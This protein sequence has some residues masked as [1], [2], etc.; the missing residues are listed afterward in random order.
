MP[1][2]RPNACAAT[3]CTLHLLPTPGKPARRP[4]FTNPALVS[5]ANEAMACLATAVI[6]LADLFGLPDA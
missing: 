5:K 6:Y 2:A 1:Q 3:S 4:L